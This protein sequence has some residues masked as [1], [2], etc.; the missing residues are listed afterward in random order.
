MTKRRRFA[1]RIAV[2]A[3]VATTLLFA[4]ACLFQAGFGLVRESSTFAG[5]AR[6]SDGVLQI[7]LRNGQMLLTFDSRPFSLE[8][9]VPPGGWHIE[10]RWGPSLRIDVKQTYRTA[11][12]LG[13][14]GFV[15]NGG[16]TVGFGVFLAYPA[17]LA[18]GV[19]CLL[20]PPRRD[21]SRCATCG[22]DLRATPDRCPECGTAVLDVAQA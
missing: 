11:S 17:A 7:I 14:D 13:L 8:G 2:A 3:A 9:V 6:V 5:G 19:A 20:A 1:F 4:F 10:S 22:Y 15:A 12:E 21:P 18:W 16:Q